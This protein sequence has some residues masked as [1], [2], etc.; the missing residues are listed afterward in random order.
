MSVKENIT[1]FAKSQ[2]L[3]ISDFEK[4]IGVSNGYVNSISKSI[5]IDKIHSLL[6]K[7]PIVNIEWILTGKGKMLKTENDFY[8][9]SFV[10]SEPDSPFVAAPKGRLKKPV[11]AGELINFYDIDFAAGDIEFYNDTIKPAY[12]MDI[13]EFAG[14]TAFR[15]YSDSMETLIASGNILFA[16]KVKDWKDGGLE[17]GQIYGITRHDNRR[18]LKYIRKAADKEETHYLLKSE[19]TAMY[20]DFLLEKR[21]I[22]SIWLIHGWINKRT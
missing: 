17:Y 15:T 19:N 14:C 6:E 16:T 9:N 2:N 1:K 7:F 10:V 8:V 5:G 21:K 11:K 3:A 22:R 18:H 4:I 12:T 13:P 20:D